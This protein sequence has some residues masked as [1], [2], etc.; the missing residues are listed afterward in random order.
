MTIIGVAI[1]V[2]DPA[3]SQLR[4]YRTGFGDRLAASVPTHVTLLPPTPV[5][6][7]ELDAIDEHLTKV[8]SAAAP[9][10]IHLRGTGTF[11]PVSPVVFVTLAEG[12]AACELLQEDLRTGPLQIDLRFPFHPH[13][14][15]AHDLDERGLDHAYQTLAG[16]EAIFEVTEFKRYEHGGDGVWRP[17]QTYVLEAWDPAAGSP[18]RPNTAGWKR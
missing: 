18:T 14:T 11:R 13:V 2:P 7:D 15:V 17:R 8:A 1:E 6:G 5:S 3:G 10:R 4:E 16:F 9:F 12:V